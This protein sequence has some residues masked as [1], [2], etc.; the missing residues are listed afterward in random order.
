MKKQIS[1]TVYSTFVIMLIFFG[2]ST[3]PKTEKE[4]VQPTSIKSTVWDKNDSETISDS[5]IL[6]ALKADWKKNFSK[7]GKPIVVVGRIENKSGKDI[8]VSLLA[9]DIERSLINSGEVSFIADKPKR[10]VI[11]TNRKNESDFPDNKKFKKYLK[12]LKADF[13][14]TGDI[15]SNVDSS[16]VPIEKMYTMNLEIINAKNASVVWKGSQS[17]TK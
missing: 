10:E 3:T 4:Q 5:L 15:N 1:I 8:D 16:V 2:C 14:I 6:S 12:S 7:K 11:R 9:K 13:F 17:L